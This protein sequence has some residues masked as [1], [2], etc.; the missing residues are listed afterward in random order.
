MTEHPQQPCPYCGKAVSP[1][2]KFCPYCG[3]ALSPTVQTPA[4]LPSDAE[5]RASGTGA[6]PLAQCEMIVGY[7]V[8]H[9]CDN[10]A[11]G[12]CIKCGRGYCEE[13]VE[14]RP[15]G[16]LCLACLQGLAQ[17]IALPVTAQTYTPAD[18]A[19]F[20]AASTWDTDDDDAFADL[21]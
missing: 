5:M 3:S 12:R 19:V 20:D 11:L 1:A 15:E 21:S 8:P 14:V 10:P 16:L 4:A 18:I 13:H 2:A 7:L 9:R 6:A 17:P